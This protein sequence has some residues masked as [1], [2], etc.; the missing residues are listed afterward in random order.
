MN[1]A[2]LKSSNGEKN[3]KYC[4]AIDDHLPYAYNMIGSMYATVE[5]QS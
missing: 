3:K 4:S 2:V 5:Q 1:I